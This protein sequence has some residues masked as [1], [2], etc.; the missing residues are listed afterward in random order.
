MCLNSGCFFCRKVSCCY[1]CRVGVLLKWFI[2][3]MMKCRFWWLFFIDWLF[4]LVNLIFDFF[5]KFGLMGIFKIWFVVILLFV[6][7]NC[8]FLIFIFLLMLLKSFFSVSGNG[9]LIVVILGVV[10]CFFELLNVDWF[11]EFCFGW[12]LLLLLVNWE[13]IFFW[14]LLFMLLVW[15]WKNF[16]KMFFG[17]VKLKLLLFLFGLLLVLKWNDCLLFLLG[18]LLKLNFL[19]ILLVFVKGLFLVLLFGGGVVFFFS[20]NL[21]LYW[22]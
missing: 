14:L 6:L 3:L 13:K 16:W 18:I 2:F 10:L 7:L 17:F 4:I 21:R 19:G 11:C 5:F 12:L 1:M 15:E 22:L 20:K 8:F 9:F